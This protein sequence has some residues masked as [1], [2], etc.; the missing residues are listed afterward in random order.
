M[1]KSEKIIFHIQETYES[2]KAK[3]LSSTL[4]NKLILAG[5]VL[6]ILT[7]IGKKLLSSTATTPSPA[8]AIETSEN[9]DALIPTDS[10]M[11]PISVINQESL[12]S[13]LGTYGVVDLYTPP[14]GKQPAKKVAQAIKLVRSPKNEKQFV[15]I[16]PE[17]MAAFLIQ[18]QN[19]FFVT[20]LSQNKNQPTE[21]L[22]PA[23]SKKIQIT[24]QE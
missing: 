11:V 19:S 13:I 1:Q 5:V 6:I 24:Y 23:G 17:S 2:L 3:V 14:R 21:Y 7:L 15:A 22:K 20:V 10:V 9:L 4:E 18:S 8:A 12:E 16:V